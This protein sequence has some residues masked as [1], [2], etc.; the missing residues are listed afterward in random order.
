VTSACLFVEVVGCVHSKASRQTNKHQFST[1]FYICL[2]LVRVSH[3]DAQLGEQLAL[4]LLVT[5]L[6]MRHLLLHCLGL[7]AAGI[8]R[9]SHRWP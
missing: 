4:E 3:L 5:L 9:A 2:I 7:D 1:Q 6:S 8:R